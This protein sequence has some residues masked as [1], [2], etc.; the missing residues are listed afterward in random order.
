MTTSKEPISCKFEIDGK[1]V[2]QVMEFNHLGVN[3]ISSGNLVKKLK[4]KLKK[5]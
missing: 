1:I 3:I 5:Q 4:P 2:K